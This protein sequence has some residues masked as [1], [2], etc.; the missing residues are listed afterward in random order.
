MKNY[1]YLCIILICIFIN[2]NQLSSQLINNP[3]LLSK[4]DSMLIVQKN[5][6]ITYK[7]EIFEVLTRKMTLDEKQGLKFI[8]AFAPLSD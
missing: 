4:I 3:R 1:R 5:I 7:N 2:T 6:A 8:L